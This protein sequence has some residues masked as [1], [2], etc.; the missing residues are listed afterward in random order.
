MKPQIDP[1]TLQITQV[2]LQFI[3][4]SFVKFICQFIAVKGKNPFCG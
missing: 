4:K 3:V 1:F 2:I